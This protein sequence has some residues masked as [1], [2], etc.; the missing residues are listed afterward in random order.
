MVLEAQVRD[1]VRA[2]DCNIVALL[3]GWGGAGGVG[4][5]RWGVGGFISRA[6]LDRLDRSKRRVS[7]E[8]RTP[9]NLTLVSF[10]SGPRLLHTSAFFQN[11]YCLNVRLIGAR[12]LKAP[13]LFLAA[14]VLLVLARLASWITLVL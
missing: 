6:E 4:G 1:I 5:V 3:L 9:I 10:C 11:R 12:R 13:V 2:S 8:N 14:G 7:T